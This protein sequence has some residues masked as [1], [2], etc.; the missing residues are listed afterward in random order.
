MTRVCGASALPALSSAAKVRV[1]T[2]PAVIG[3]L[4]V[5]PLIVV[6]AIVC[7]PVALK[8][9][10]ATRERLSRAERPTVTAPRFQPLAFG[11]GFAAAVVFGARMSMLIPEA[12]ALAVLSSRSLKS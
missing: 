12:V 4:A 2:P 7:A 10:D 6:D 3:T 5:A 8:V 9:I 1:V 11:A